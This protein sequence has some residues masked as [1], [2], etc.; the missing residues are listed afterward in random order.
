MKMKVENLQ[1]ERNYTLHRFRN[2]TIRSN[3]RT[4]PLGK[5]VVAAIEMGCPP[6]QRS[7]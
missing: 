3:P 1:P 2:M 6:Q 7:R 4:W 5:T